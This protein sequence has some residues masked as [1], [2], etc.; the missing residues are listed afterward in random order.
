MTQPER[1]LF[2]PR[3]LPAALE[4]DD[5]ET[6]ASFYEMFI[7]V[8]RESLLELRECHQGADLATLEHIAH[9]LKSSSASIGAI[10]LAES[11]KTI[12]SLAAAK[13]QGEA[14]QLLPET[15]AIATLSINA[16]QQ[17][18]DSLVRR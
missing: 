15:S 8:T 9:K 6:L 16:V 12:E 4:M 14:Y 7:M 13:L 1:P 10:K 3:V 11:F 5:P 2:D 18:V 17:H